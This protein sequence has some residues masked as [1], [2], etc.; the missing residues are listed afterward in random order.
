M[1]LSSRNHAC[2]NEDCQKFSGLAL[3]AICKRKV[4]LE[5][6]CEYFLNMKINEEKLVKTYRN[7]IMD[8]EDLYKLGQ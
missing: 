1:T 4:L 7:E 2:V 5:K 6:S 8:I 3:K